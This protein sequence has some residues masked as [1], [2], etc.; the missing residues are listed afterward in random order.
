MGKKGWPLLPSAKKTHP[1][2]GAPRGAGQS[3][4]GWNEGVKTGGSL[5]GYSFVRLISWDPFS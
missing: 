4:G 1:T 5:E 3:W 2:G